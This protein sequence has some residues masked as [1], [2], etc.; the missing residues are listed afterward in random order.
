M[1]TAELAAVGRGIECC[2]PK[3]EEGERSGMRT[4]IQRV[5]RA[6]VRVD[7]A[8]VGAVD[9]GLCVLVGVTH[10]DGRAQIEK[11]A[12]K[13]AQLRILRSS[14]GGDD[15]RRY[16]RGSGGQPC[17]S[18]HHVHVY[19]DVRQREAAGLVARRPRRCR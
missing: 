19:A 12:R 2:R 6:E 14:D 5:R 4:V 18:S 17:S 15:E 7:G 10:G 3:D 13:I 11:T 1:W 9:A 8:V 16:G